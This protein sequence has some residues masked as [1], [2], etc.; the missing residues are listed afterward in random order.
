MRRFIEEI[1]D[2]P[3]KG[4]T[5][6]LVLCLIISGIGVIAAVMLVLA[7]KFMHV[8]EDERIGKILLNCLHLI[9]NCCSSLS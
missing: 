5:L 3:K 1:K 4:D 2:F 7:A 6:L 8:E 9:P